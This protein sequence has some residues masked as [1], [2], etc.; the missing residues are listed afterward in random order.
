MEEFK[1]REDWLRWRKTGLGASDSPV[2]L[3]LSSYKTIMNIY[4]SK[5]S[6]EIVEEKNFASDL[7][8]EAE[9]KIRSLFEL[10]FGGPYN[11]AV[12]ANGIFLA[13]LDGRSD[14]KEE[15]LE[16]KLSGKEKYEQAVK[17]I[18]PPEYMVQ[19]QHQLMVTGAKLCRFVSYPFSLYKETRKVDQPDRLIVITVLPDEDMHGNIKHE[20]AKF[21]N[22]HVLKKKP[23][24][25]TVGDYVPLTGYAI[26]ADQWKKLS[27]QAKEV[28][29]KLEHVRKE[30]IKRAEET[31][32]SR[33]L[34]AGI[35][36]TKQSRQGNVN[37]SKIAELKGVDLDQYRSAGSTFWKLE[38]LE[39]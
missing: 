18:V 28:G 22:E 25:A 15:I 24:V 26:L 14:N 6:E 34:C 27:L 12:I 39:K 33:I 16:I 35:K 2:I 37:Y 21:W 1:S 32:H 20:G 10:L 5:V 13:S 4:E 30:L 31:P 29:E 8:I 38:E 7:G 11:P 23:P 9:P 19:I 36:M 17:G 3:G